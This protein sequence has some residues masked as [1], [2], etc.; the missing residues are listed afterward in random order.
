MAKHIGFMEYS[1]EDAKK[2]AVK[3]RV[4]DFREFE[5][6]LPPDRLRNQAARCMDCGVPHCHTFGCPT[7]N[8]IPDWNDLVYKGQWK[9]ALDN[10]LSTDNFPEFTG[11]ICPAPC[12]AACTLA[13]NSP[14]VTIRQI[15]LQIIERAWKE[16]WVKPEPPSFKTGKRVAVVGSG[17]SGLAAAQQLVRLG[18]EVVVFE[19]DDRIG[20]LLRY[21]IPDFKLEKWVI[22]RRLEQMQQ[23]GVIFET[24]VHV[25]KDVSAH[26]LQR[27]FNAI[28]IAAG[29]TVPRDVQVPGREAKGIHFAMEFLTQQNRMNAGECIDENARISAEGKDVVVIGGGDTGSDCVGTSTRQGAKSIT[30]IE[31]LPKPP[32]QRVASNPWPTWPRILYTSSSHE[33][34]CDRDWG[35]STKRFITE[36]GAVKKI[37]AVRLEWSE[38]EENGR[39]T[40]KEIPGS[41]FELKADLVL[42][43]AGFVHLDHGPLV[44]ELG[45]DLDAR[46]NVVADRNLMTSKLGVFAAGDAVMGAS[47]VVRA[48]YQGR[49]AAAGVDRYLMGS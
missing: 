20:G 18:H 48:L 26:Y 15:E 13:I 6:L 12:E 8:R 46:G 43:A 41:E 34:G 33:E 35:I 9:R 45:L 31:I 42:L 10:L 7:K 38:A 37:K 36:N 49:E 39:Y 29:A 1:R 17:P 21:G 14:A 23:E 2:R 32:A 4:R 28:L 25:G 5:E 30:Q 40:S 44:S 19:R 11:R 22:D 27:S 3:L 24:Q 16:G 47:L